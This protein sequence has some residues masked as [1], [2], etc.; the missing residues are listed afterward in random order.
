MVSIYK[1]RADKFDRYVFQICSYSE[2]NYKDLELF[3][4]KEPK[5]YYHQVYDETDTAKR[6]P[7]YRSQLLWEPNIELQRIVLRFDFFTSNNTGVYEISLEGF[8]FD[9]EPVSLKERFI[10]E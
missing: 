3:K 2:E 9:G 6:I 5:Q 4:P 10:V 8:T 7:D 1:N